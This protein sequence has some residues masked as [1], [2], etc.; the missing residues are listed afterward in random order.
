MRHIDLT[1]LI[2][3]LVVLAACAVAP[4]PAP[5]GVHPL[6]VDTGS[7]APDTATAPEE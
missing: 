7:S 4:W 2:G 6:H 5:D 3:A 1:W